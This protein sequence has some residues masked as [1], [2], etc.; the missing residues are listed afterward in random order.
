ML[1]A[2][3]S[4][5]VS[6]A[7]PE[8]EV[9]YPAPESPAD[10]RYNDLVEILHEALEHTAATYGPYKVH[11]AHSVMNEARELQTLEA[12]EEIN[13]AWSSTSDEKEQHLLP[14]RIPLRKGLLGYRIA[15]ISKDEQALLDKVH[16]ADDLRKFTIGQGIGW[17]DVA[18]YNRNGFKVLTANYENLFRMAEVRRFDLFPRGIGEVFKEYDEH[19]KLN[20]NLVVEQHLLIQYPWPYYFFFNR[21]DTALAERVETGLRA[22]MK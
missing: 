18:L 4:S 6:A 16:D 5:L 10:V 22:M 1:I 9:I 11:P 15:L 12:G 14:I 3:M 20:P 17:G 21:K 8:L 19:V 2:I 7:A 13:I